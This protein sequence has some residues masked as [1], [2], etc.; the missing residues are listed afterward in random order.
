MQGKYKAV[1]ISME[2]DG[3]TREEAVNKD[4]L[5]MQ[6]EVSKNRDLVIRELELASNVLRQHIATRQYFD[7][8]TQAKSRVDYAINMMLDGKLWGNP[9][10]T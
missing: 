9:W 2:A 5:E 10:T 8:T 3:L 4:M 1:A 6:E 7:E